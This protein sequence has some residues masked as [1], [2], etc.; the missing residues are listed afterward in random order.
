MKIILASPH[1][2]QLRGN[3]IT[4]QRISDNLEKLD[5]ETEI[6][7][8]TTDASVRSLPTADIVHGFHA[9]NFYHFLQQL[10]TKPAHYIITMTGTDLNLDLFDPDKRLDVLACLHEADAIHVF[11]KKAEELLLKEIPWLTNKVFV[12]PQGTLSSFTASSSFTKEPGSFL[13]FL[14]AGIRKVKNI[15]AAITMLEKLHK[16][17]PQ[18]RLW[19]LGPILE[20]SENQI[21]MDL[22]DQHKE[23]IQYLGQVP[24]E[25]MGSI[26]REVDVVLNTSLSEGQPASILEAMSY[27]LPVLASDIPGNNLI[28]NKVTGLLYKNQIEF[29]DYAEKLMNNNKIRE[30]IG[31]AAE[32]YVSQY[33]SSERE[34]ETFLKVYQAILK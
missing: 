3:T 17:Y 20:E 6:I 10:D 23:W 25:V 15:P 24:H 11:N 12:L 16:H 19:L 1:Y 13:F 28:S 26:Y 2:P 34:A 22:V 9:Y 21:V 5:V 33:H 31:R 32:S 4:V 18:L 8:T 30:S 29:L 14:P 27:A 7:S